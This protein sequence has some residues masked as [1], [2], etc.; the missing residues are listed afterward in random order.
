MLHYLTHKEFTV[1]P[2]RN[3][4]ILVVRDKQHD[5]LINKLQAARLKSLRVLAAPDTANSP[6]EELAKLQWLRDEG[7]ITAEECAR[8]CSQT[9]GTSHDA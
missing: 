9:P 3:G 5:I 2:A 6:D 8:L 1:I 7:A 4:G